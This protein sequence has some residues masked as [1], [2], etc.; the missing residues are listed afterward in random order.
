MGGVNLAH[1]SAALTFF[2]RLAWEEKHREK[3]GSATS[4][5]ACSK[6]PSAVHAHGSTSPFLGYRNELKILSCQAELRPITDMKPSS[7]KDQHVASGNEQVR[8]I[9]PNWH[10]RNITSSGFSMLTPNLPMP[11]YCNFASIFR[12]CCLQMLFG[13]R[14]GSRPELALLCFILQGSM[15]CMSLQRTSGNRSTITLEA[16]FCPMGRLH[17]VWCNY[18][19]TPRKERVHG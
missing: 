15:Q 16:V 5:R 13:W 3:H 12:S 1:S 9:A 10:G 17:A 7:P 14:S 6:F 4:A 8:L 19:P 11:A 2:W 18:K